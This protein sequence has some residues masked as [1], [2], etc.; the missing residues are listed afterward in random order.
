MR[1]RSG[2]MLMIVLA[3]MSMISFAVGALSL[4]ATHQLRLGAIPLNQ[5]KQQALSQAAVEQAIVLLAKDDPALDS[6]KEAWATGVDPNTQQQL[7]QEAA[8]G[9]GFFSIGESDEEGFHPGLVD[10]QSKLDLNRADV[11]QL[12][13]LIASVAP[14]GVNAQ[15]VAMIIADWRDEP[16]GDFCGQ[17]EAPCH[18]APFESVDELLAVP[19]VTPALFAALKPYV[20]IYGSGMV[21]VNTASETVLQALG[22]QAQ[23]LIQ[24][25]SRQ[26]FASPPAECPSTV[27][28]SSAFSADVEAAL[29]PSPSRTRLHVVLSRQGCQA[30]P[31]E[32]S[33]CILSWQPS[34]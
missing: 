20:T 21:N 24:Q 6:L 2:Q 25:R 34:F 29:N 26:P 9:E 1:S 23:T 19:Q 28:V 14:E 27:V 15:E 5:I 10:E 33:R 12:A 16:V 32:G 17:S 4:R 13:Q 8:V 22:C 3:V 18:N 11:Q 30:N 7:L 31:P